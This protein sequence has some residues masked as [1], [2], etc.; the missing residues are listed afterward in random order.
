MAKWNHAGG[1]IQNENKLA[2][3]N[4]DKIS[5]KKY[6]NLYFFKLSDNLIITYLYLIASIFL[7]IINR[8]LY[9]KYNFKFNFTLLFLQQLFCTIFFKIISLSSKTFKEKVGEVSFRD[10]KKNQAQYL[11]FSIIFSFNYLC[12]FIGNQMV[13]TA[14]YLVLKK[15]IPVMNFLYDKYINKKAL[16]NYFS[17]SVMFILAGSLLTGWADL[18][19]DGL[20]YFVVFANNFFSVFYGQMSDGFSKKNG[21]SNL[22]LL[23]YNGYLATPILFSCIFISGEYKR[24]MAYDG[25][26]YGLIS[27]VLLS[28]SL[29]VVLNS[30]YF[31]SNEKNSSLFT[32]LLSNSKV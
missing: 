24:L 21:V 4:S 22:K 27:L 12:S 20:G 29:A 30:S 11:F 14:M 10:F 6:I 13:N 17:Q 31:I 26:S 23:V 32:Q 15:F 2:K 3:T 19:S 9:Q 5:E 18:T 1:S 28:M 7:N 16:P 25:Y 8:V